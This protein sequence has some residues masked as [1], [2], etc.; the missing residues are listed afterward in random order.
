MAKNLKWKRS[1]HVCPHEYIMVKD[2]PY[3]VALIRASKCTEKY[4]GVTYHVLFLKGFKYW[5][6]GNVINRK[7][8]TLDTWHENDLVTDQTIHK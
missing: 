7:R 5:R 4:R 2:S 6:M 1:K 3:L 8:Q